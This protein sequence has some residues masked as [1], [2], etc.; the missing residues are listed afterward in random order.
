MKHPEQNMQKIM[1][2][3]N[4]GA[5]KS[6]LALALGKAKHLPVTHLDR[7]IWR[8]N[9]EAISEED[10]TQDHDKILSEDRWLVEGMGYDSTIESRFARSDTIVYIDF[11][12][13]THFRWALKRSVKSV[14]VKPE[15][16]AEGCQPISKF[17]YM[18]RIM[19]DVHKKTRPYL[20][21]LIEKYRD[22]KRVF[23]LRSPKELQVFYAQQCAV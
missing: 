11:P 14:V 10:F 23:H 12:L 18:L 9:W 6:T 4:G 17:G 20:L 22:Q 8:A 21:S 3:G 19:W 7:V 16:W 13:V 5:G 15:G 2:I 1:I